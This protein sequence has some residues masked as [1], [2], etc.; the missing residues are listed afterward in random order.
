VP[1]FR[2]GQLRSPGELAQITGGG[3]EFDPGGISLRDFILAAGGG[4]SIPIGSS[5]WIRFHADRVVIDSFSSHMEY[6]P[7]EAID[8]L[9]VSGSTIR[10]SLGVFGGGFGVIGAAEGMLAAAVINRLTRRTR[11]YAVL[12]IVT[13]TAEY[14]LSSTALDGSALALTLTPVQVA[15]RKARQAVRAGSTAPQ[16]SIADELSKL[17]RLHDEGILTEEEFA[18]AKAKLLGS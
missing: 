1:D 10:S 18:A 11:Q 14:V 16:F 8:A 3:A 17:A 9:Q 12:R 15:I 2:A 7:F 13:S 4:T 5:C 6:I